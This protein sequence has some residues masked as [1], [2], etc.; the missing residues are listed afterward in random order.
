MARQNPKK[1]R[2][3]ATIAR[4]RKGSHRRN[5]WGTPPWLIARICCDVFHGPIQLDPATEPHNPTNAVHK[6]TIRDNGLRRRWMDCTFCNPPYGSALP[7]WIKRII[8]QARRGYRIVALVPA[9]PDSRHAQELL[10]AATDV[11]MFRGRLR[12]DSFDKFRQ[13]NG[14]DFGHMLVSFNCSLDRLA[15]LG[16]LVCR[17]NDEEVAA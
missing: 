16:W 15:D 7:K 3:R 13:K 1:L 5:A 11:L 12:H 2:K 4:H 9:R 10:H 17:C 14:P 6:Y 8:A